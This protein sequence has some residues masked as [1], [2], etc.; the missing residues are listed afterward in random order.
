MGS[1]FG[2]FVNPAKCCL[3]VDRPFLDEAQCL[4]SNL[5]IR[6]VCVQR[7][8]GGFLGESVS[9]AAFVEQKVEQ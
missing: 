8:L 6:I 3:V 2:Y 5:G 7:Y 4:F 9:C 1:N